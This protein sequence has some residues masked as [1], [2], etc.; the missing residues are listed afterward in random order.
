MNLL[1]FLSGKNIY[2][3]LSQVS[4]VFTANYREGGVWKK[5]ENTRCDCTVNSLDYIRMR[6]VGQR[7]SER[8]YTCA[9]YVV[10]EP[11]LTIPLGVQI[12]GQSCKKFHNLYVQ[13]ALSQQ[14]THLQSQQFN[15]MMMMMTQNFE[16]YGRERSAGTVKNFT[17]RVCLV[18]TLSQQFKPAESVV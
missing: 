15:M 12:M 8:V 16:S 1:L 2:H 9:A 18:S 7:A 4:Q 3:N 13:S 10:P 11:G 17:I 5:C 14:L 6:G